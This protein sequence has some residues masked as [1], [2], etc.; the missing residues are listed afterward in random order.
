[1]AHRASKIWALRMP[2]GPTKVIRSERLIDE[3]Q[4]KKI[5]MGSFKFVSTENKRDTIWPLIKPL[6]ETSV[7]EYAKFTELSNVT[8]RPRALVEV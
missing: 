5:Y 4:A 2:G 6:D 1:M 7:L 8:G 3:D